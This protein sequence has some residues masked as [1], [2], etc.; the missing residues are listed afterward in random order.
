MCW[1]PQ[2][3]FVIPGFTVI[4]HDRD[5]NPSGGGCATF[6]IDEL[7]YREIACP[8]EAECVTI[9]LC[10]TKKYGNV[11]LINFYNSCGNLKNEIFREIAGKVIRRDIW[12]GDFSA[13]YRLWGSHHSDSNGNL[14]EEMMEERSL[15]CLDDTQ[16][17]RI[18]VNRGTVS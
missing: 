5:S 1:R 2:L 4:R 15:V 11:R 17:T 18:N 12:C 3:D 6:I 9:E 16:G 7:T 8:Q 14:V 13:H 10:N